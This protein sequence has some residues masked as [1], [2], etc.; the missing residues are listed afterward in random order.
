MPKDST[1]TIPEGFIRH[2][3][4][5]CPVPGDSRPDVMHANGRITSGALANDWGS[6]LGDWW[7]HMRYTEWNIIAY[8]PDPNY[9]PLIDRQARAEKLVAALKPFAEAWEIAM[10]KVDL[11]KSTLG[12]IS[13]I[14]KHHANG[15]DYKV[16][17]AALAEWEKP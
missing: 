3:G 4:G 14:A 12:D 6:E 2:D 13:A 10:Q 1:P 17:S 11:S 15:A 9:V 8:L 16:A 5:E 7:K